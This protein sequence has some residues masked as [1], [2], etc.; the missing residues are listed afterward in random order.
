M[1]YLIIALMLS[2]LTKCSN[3][4]SNGNDEQK[5]NAGA[6]ITGGAKDQIDGQ[7]NGQDK[8]QNNS[9]NNSQNKIKER[10]SNYCK[11]FLKK[12]EEMQSNE[13]LEKIIEAFYHFGQECSDSRIDWSKILSN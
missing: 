6:D 13:D 8:G 7:N 2:F 12:L 4:S 9:Q 11:D 5:K 10:E 3:G 1:K